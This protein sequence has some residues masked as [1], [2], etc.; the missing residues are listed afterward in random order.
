MKLLRVAIIA[1][2]TLCA[3]EAYAGPGGCT[4]QGVLTPFA[5]ETLTISSTAIGLTAATFNPSGGF[6][7]ALAVCTLE[8]DSVR[9][10]VNGLNPTA[11]VGQII[12]ASASAPSQLTVCGFQSLANVRFI[13]VTTDAT[14]T[15][16]YYREG[17]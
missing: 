3:G 15:C 10:R 1:A 14:L 12:T 8:T 5:D 17:N 4:N 11:A 16:S 13:R 7:A 6:P 9:F 2:L